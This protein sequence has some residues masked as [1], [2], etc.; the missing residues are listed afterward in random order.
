MH[1]GLFK[2]SKDGIRLVGEIGDA[3]DDENW[4]HRYFT[5]GSRLITKMASMSPM[6][7]DR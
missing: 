6:L 7:N 4:R 3:R 2:F 1:P 5:M